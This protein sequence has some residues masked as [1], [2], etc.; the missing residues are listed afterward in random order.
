MAL[1]IVHPST[2]RAFPYSSLLTRAAGA[3]L[4]ASIGGWDALRPFGAHDLGVFTV[5]RESIVAV[6]MQL[7]SSVGAPVPRHAR[8]ASAVVLC[9]RA[10]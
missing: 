1:G 2:L 10:S 6:L 5:S 3:T 7:P 9:G 8:H 4:G